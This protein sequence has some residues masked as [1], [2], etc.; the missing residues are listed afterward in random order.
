MAGDH[1]NA[2]VRP[3]GLDAPQHLDAVDIRHP[4]VEQNERWVLA[5]DQVHHAGGIAGVEHAKPFVAEDSTQ[6]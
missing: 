2:D 6:R 1:D 4:D 3:L 5:C